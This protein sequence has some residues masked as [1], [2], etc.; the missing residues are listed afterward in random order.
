MAE[1]VKKPCV[2]CAKD[3]DGVRTDPGQCLHC[4]EQCWPV[5]TLCPACRDAGLCPVCGA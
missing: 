3:D 5:E 1:S 2:C 4:G